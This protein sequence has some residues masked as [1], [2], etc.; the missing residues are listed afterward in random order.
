MLSSTLRTLRR[1]RSLTLDQLAEKSGVNRGTIHRIET[2]EVSP[3]IDT[4]EAICRAL[5]V[6]VGTLF[7]SDP[8]AGEAGRPDLPCRAGAPGGAQDPPGIRQG[9]MEWFEHLEAIIH[10]SMDLLA[11]LD[12]EGYILYESWSTIKMLGTP[13]GHR[14]CRPWWD[15]VHGEDRERVMAH[16][17]AVCRSRTQ[18]PALDYRVKHRNGG[19]RWV[20]SVFSNQLNHPMIRGILVNSIDITQPKELELRLE[21]SEKRL[22]AVVQAI[23]DVYFRLNLEGLVLDCQFHG[24]KSPLQDWNPL[25]RHFLE[26]PLPQPVLEALD[27]SVRTAVAT[28][29]T[30]VLDYTLPVDH[31]EHHREARIAPSGGDEVVIFVRDYPS[32]RSPA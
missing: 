20:R 29:Q 11:V 13:R 5:G 18:P 1:S 26:A 8:G 25:G 7:H 2:D 3:R 23:P 28:R 19:W 16:F 12:M 15:W 14:A 24:L 17:R 9:L 6:Q 4:L 21:D 10:E 27:R 31:R 32:R 22:Q 30:Q